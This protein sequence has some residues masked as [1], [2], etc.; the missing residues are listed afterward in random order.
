MAR[1][2]LNFTTRRLWLKRRKIRPITLQNHY[3]MIHWYIQNHP[4]T[5]ARTCEDILWYR[6]I[7][8]SYSASG[9]L[10]PG[11]EMEQ[12]K[13]QV[14]YVFFRY[15][16]VLYIYS[17]PDQKI[18]TALLKCICNNPITLGSGS[19]TETSGNVLIIEH[20]CEKCLS[21]QLLLLF[22]V[23]TPLQIS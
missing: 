5:Q 1:R 16:L 6:F 22:W 9:R 14:H 12:C 17:M 13:Q 19:N 20:Y 23:N 8:R 15:L 21:V 3:N 4:P 11:V 10:P 18:Y 7:F 2:S